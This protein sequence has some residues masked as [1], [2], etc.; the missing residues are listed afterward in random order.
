[1]HSVITRFRMKRDSW[2]GYAEI[3]LS[4]HNCC[5]LTGGNGEGK[6][7]MMKLLSLVGKWYNHPNKYNTIQIEDLALKSEV[8]S[9]EVEIKSEIINGHGP[10]C[11]TANWIKK[12]SFD[13]MI[14]YGGENKFVSPTLLDSNIKLTNEFLIDVHCIDKIHFSFDQEN[15]HQ[16]DELVKINRSIGVSYLIRD[17]ENMNEDDQMLK[18]SWDLGAELPFT[19]IFD[20][21]KFDQINNYGKEVIEYAEQY[22]SE[23]YQKLEYNNY[24]SINSNIDIVQEFDQSGLTV[25]EI[26]S[27]YGINIEVEESLVA[28]L[29][30]NKRQISQ[31][32]ILKVDRNLLDIGFDM[33]QVRLTEKRIS[34]PNNCIKIL[35]SG[36]KSYKD[37]NRTISPPSLFVQLMNNS[38]MSENFDITEHIDDGG[39]ESLYISINEPFFPSLWAFKKFLGNVPEGSYLS[40]G[41]LQL[42]S[43]TKAVISSSSNSLI[44]IDE[45]ELSLHIDWQRKLINFMSNAFPKHR[46]I[47]ATHSPDIL[48]EQYDNVIQI[49]PVEQ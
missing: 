41:Q 34:D 19:P 17:Y 24:S 10:Y 48:Y 1:M 18:A 13:P 40:S 44:M 22:C 32:I 49:P 2:D 7:L 8:S 28:T 16:S 36:W 47:F 37:T 45:P 25:L 39:L 31:P 27:N 21:L 12:W 9:I 43:M 23:N 14:V 3:D 42:L 35:K 15:I 26:L 29:E 20:P 46:F 38:V 4:E 30:L 6:T 5:V 33:E 11:A